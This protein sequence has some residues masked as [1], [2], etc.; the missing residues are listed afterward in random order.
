MGNEHLQDADFWKDVEGA[1]LQELIDRLAALPNPT[2]GER[3]KLAKARIALV[4]VQAEAER[5]AALNKKWQTGAVQVDTSTAACEL[6]MDVFF[7]PGDMP[8]KLPY[9]VCSFCNAKLEQ[10]TATR[11]TGKVKVSTV[12]DP[13][14]IG[15]E[16]TIVERKVVQAEKV[17]AC[18]KCAGKVLKPIVTSRV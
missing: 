17:Q 2:K 3:N 8:V 13:V 15:D 7:V 5:L 16:I 12:T 6:D 4:Q 14:V 10:V 18:P 9:P 11:G 1:E